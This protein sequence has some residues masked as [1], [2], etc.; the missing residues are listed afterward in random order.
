MSDELI[1]V[2]D[3]RPHRGWTELA[4]LRSIEQGPH[5]F[6]LKLTETWDERTI[7]PRTIQAGM[8]CQVYVDD[9]Q[10]LSGY[11]DDIDPAYDA[12]NHSL[13]VRGR[14]KLGDL[15][16]CSTTGG[17]TTQGR[18]LE[19]IARTFCKPFGI[20]VVV[21]A[22]ARKAANK[23]FATNDN[24]LDN[25]QPIWEFLEEL[26]RIRAVLL[27][28][29]IQGNLVITRA[30]TGHADVA[31]ELGSN[32]KSASGT[33]SYRELFSEYT[34]TGQQAGSWHTDTADTSQPIATQ[35]GDSK[36]YRPFVVSSD[37]PADIAACRA[38]ATWQRNVHYGRS[39]GVTY[40][41]EG[42]RQTPAGRIWTPNELVTI[43]DEWSGLDNAER[44]VVETRIQLNDRSGSL[45]QLRTMPKEAFD[46]V[47]LPES[48]STWGT[49]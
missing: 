42:W 19:D 35:K 9:D 14:S 40:S 44:L 27:V 18:S 23:P 43:N 48:T 10:I 3:G 16:D 39:Q 8:A 12:R 46:L 4:V 22:S 6:D 34:V 37:N 32:I 29:D 7:S 5:S 11:V 45:T 36:R 38:R 13:S 26:A 33:F 47:P 20:D 15:V 30:G 41:V 25:G 31:L 2:L 21:D 1:L 28:S 24:V 17:Q 49:P